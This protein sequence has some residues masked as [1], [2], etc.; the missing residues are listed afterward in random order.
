MSQFANLNFSH[1]SSFKFSESEQCFK[2]YT[3]ILFPFNPSLLCV[4]FVDL[5]R[6]D[7]CIKTD[8]AVYQ[9][10]KIGCFLSP[11]M[12]MRYVSVAFVH[13]A[14]GSFFNLLN[15]VSGMHLVCM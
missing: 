2:S 14:H 6:R 9:E 10:Y 4:H 15:I 8:G 13:I 7:P 11:F 3:G 1:L 12:E 5:L